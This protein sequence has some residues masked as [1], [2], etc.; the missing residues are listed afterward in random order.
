[1]GPEWNHI[2]LVCLPTINLFVKNFSMNLWAGDGVA[3]LAGTIEV[4]D[5]IRQLKA[6]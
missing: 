5:P 3:V 1:M 4:K 2:Y 6:K